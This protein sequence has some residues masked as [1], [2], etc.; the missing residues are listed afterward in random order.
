MTER[1]GLRRWIVAA[2]IAVVGLG[3]AA[4]DR[5]DRT[6]NATDTDTGGDALERTPIAFEASPTR[7]A[8][9]V[10]F[11][12]VLGDGVTT[13]RDTITLVN[14]GSDASAGRVELISGDG[15]RRSSEVSVP[16]GAVTT[17]AVGDLIDVPRAAAVIEMDR[18]AIS[19]DVT[20]GSEHGPAT[21]SCSSTAASEWYLADGRT[22]RDATFELALFNPFPESAVV[23]LLFATDRGTSRPTPL[24]GLNVAPGTVRII[25]VGQHVRRREAIAS[26]ITVRSGRL[27]VGMRQ[28]RT[29]LLGV[30]GSTISVGAPASASTWFIPQ[31]IVAEGL[32][33]RVSIYNPG[34]TDTSADVTLLGADVADPVT[35]NIAAGRVEIIDLGEIGAPDGEA[36]AVAVTT[37]GPGN[38]IVQRSV[39][40]VSPARRRGIATMIASP[41]AA[42]RWDIPSAAATARR[43]TRIIVMNPFDAPAQVSFRVLP[44]ALDAN[45]DA[46]GDVNGV[47]VSVG[48][49]APILDPVE[50]APGGRVEV[51]LGDTI[52]TRQS[53]IIVTSGGTGIIVQRDHLTGASGSDGDADAD[54][55]VGSRGAGVVVNQATAAGSSSSSSSS[56]PP[57][58]SPV[59]TRPAVP[60][61]SS[62]RTLSTVSTTI[63]ALP[64]TSVGSLPRPAASTTSTASAATAATTGTT[65][66]TTTALTE[67]PSNTSTSTASSTTA[68][69]TS[70]TPASTTPASTTPTSTTV[71]IAVARFSRPGLGLSSS[72]AVLVTEQ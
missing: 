5:F 47:P 63:A 30:A 15:T 68:L 19:A 22:T 31:A 52:A 26:T 64:T 45:A 44:A 8:G 58:S 51:R 49:E 12:P 1:P 71:P 29:G 46:D 11:C 42:T 43:D 35:V 10:W 24:Q 33:E 20:V 37:N 4:L 70:T 17:I 69:P 3:I 16:A 67:S 13:R 55:D 66:T 23:D 27:T 61:P 21:A 62:T 50:V 14:A 41:R 34:E 48:D 2:M 65:A 38:V 53:A 7:A 28:I 25:D 56:S 60:T 72:L 6:E 9:S 59:T 36:V 32:R 57:S 54:A 39:E 18:G 40:A